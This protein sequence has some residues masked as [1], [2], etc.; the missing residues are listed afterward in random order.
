M[1][2]LEQA[3]DALLAM[4]EAKRELIVGQMWS[5][6]YDCGCVVGTLH[7]II[8]D[9][10]KLEEY[11]AAGYGS[12]RAVRAFYKMGDWDIDAI[13]KAN[14]SF[15]LRGRSNNDDETRRARFDHVVARMR[16]LIAGGA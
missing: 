6:S 15:A 8:D 10:A 2:P 14:E 12:W 5:D 9:P 13:M 11:D 7:R 16:E 4:P 1:K 3:L